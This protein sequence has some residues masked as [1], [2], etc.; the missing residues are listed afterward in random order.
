MVANLERQESDRSGPPTKEELREFVEL[1]PSLI[2][3]IVEEEP[4]AGDEN[5]T[6]DPA[7]SEGVGH[8]AYRGKRWQDRTRVVLLGSALALGPVGHH[9]ATRTFL[10]S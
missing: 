5:L 6:P 10:I 8:V 9:R 1:I 4:V 2:M 3:A 7:K